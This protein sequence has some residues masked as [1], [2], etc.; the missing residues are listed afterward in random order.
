MSFT[1]PQDIELPQE[2]LMHALAT[3]L[4]RGVPMGIQQRQQL[5]QQQ[6]AGAALSQILNRPEI[7]EQLGSLPQ[8]LQEVL[9]K[10]ILD[11]QRQLQIQKSKAPEQPKLSNVTQQYLKDLD[12]QITGAEAVKDVGERMLKIVDN[13]SAA[14]GFREDYAPKPF[15]SEDVAEF[16]SLTF[17]LLPHYKSMFPRG[18]TNE[19]FKKIQKGALPA[20]GLTPAANRARIKNFLRKANKV[21]NKKETLE[22]IQDQFGYTPEN[23][24]N[25][26]SKQSKQ[27]K[28]KDFQTFT[29]KGEEYNIPKEHVEEFKLEMGIK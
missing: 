25:L 4:S 21:L 1:L 28:Q 9:L 24:S 5:Q 8:N 14:K 6:Q 23:I 13:I 3:G 15:K 29:I 18:I 27:S 10:G 12:K 22:K 16:E 17:D 2:G 19:E 20:L 7:A 26:I 11:Q